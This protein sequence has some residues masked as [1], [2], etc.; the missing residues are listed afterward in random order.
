MLAVSL[1]NL[2]RLIL[3]HNSISSTKSDEAQNVNNFPSSLV[4]LDLAF[5]D[6]NQWS[7]VDDL[8]TIFSG[9]KSLRLAHNPLYN[10][11]DAFILTVARLG[12][13][14][15]LNYSTITEKERLNA[16]TFYLSQ[17]A[18]ELSSATPSARKDILQRHPRYDALCKVYGE[19]TI[20]NHIAQ[21]DTLAAG[22]ARCYFLVSDA[23]RQKISAPETVADAVEL[24]LPKSFTIY[25]V[26]SMIGK[27]IKFERPMQLKLFMNEDSTELTPK[28]R[29]LETWVEGNGASIR[30]E[31]ST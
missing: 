4:E 12:H 13:L 23:V 28:T 16:E 18:R 30:V 5:N 26:Q 27:A 21:K 20:D 17:I 15:T 2:E 25:T 3:K 10:S 29:M 7:I 8:T 31:L 1:P 9:L 19:P 22:L 24:E 11:E 14:A 6:V